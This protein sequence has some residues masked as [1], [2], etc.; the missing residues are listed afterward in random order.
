MVFLSPKENLKNKKFEKR[1]DFGGILS[2]EMKNPQK[3]YI[4][5]FH[6]ISKNI[7]G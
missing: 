6:C 2:L 7:E 1:S 3:F 4:F 5:G